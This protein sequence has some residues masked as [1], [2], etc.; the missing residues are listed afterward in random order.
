M[1]VR[2]QLHT[3]IAA[4]SREL[5][6]FLDLQHYCWSRLRLRI[7]ARASNPTR[8]PRRMDSKGKP[9]MAITT[10]PAVLVTTVCCALPPCIQVPI[11]A[12]P[13]APA[14]RQAVTPR[15]AEDFKVAFAFTPTLLSL[16]KSATEPNS[17]FPYFCTCFHLVANTTGKSNEP[18]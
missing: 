9:G 6:L 1:D 4:I 7:T 2:R 11:N 13:A 12:I 18:N 10:I 3:A 14:M 17:P 5:R 16:F 15:R 8:I